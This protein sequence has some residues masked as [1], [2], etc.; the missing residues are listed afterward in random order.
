MHARLQRKAGRDKVSLTDGPTV[1]RPTLI[2]TASG[3]RYSL[4]CSVFVVWV[5]LKNPQTTIGLLQEQ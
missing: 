3:L 4:L 2:D 5:E 1:V